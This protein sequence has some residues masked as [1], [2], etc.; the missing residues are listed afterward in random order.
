MEIPISTQ[1]IKIDNSSTLDSPIKTR[2]LVFLATISLL[3][4]GIE[5]KKMECKQKRKEFLSGQ[6]K[7]PLTQLELRQQLDKRCAAWD[8][9][10][11]QRTEKENAR[12]NRRPS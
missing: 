6:Q 12:L 4:F 8:G 1:R 10:P 2:A 9:R 11:G 5:G 3:E 7:F